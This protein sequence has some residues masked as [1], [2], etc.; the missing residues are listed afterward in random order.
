M[1]TGY[2]MDP[3]TR[4]QVRRAQQRRQRRGRLVTREV[5]SAD[6]PLTDAGPATERLE[7]H[8]HDLQY[9][10]SFDS[11][12]RLSVTAS[13]DVVGRRVIDVLVS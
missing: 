9:V 11:R 10:S 2:G 8:G 4:R 13:H 12:R 1:R 6:Q 3:E 5:L 7:P